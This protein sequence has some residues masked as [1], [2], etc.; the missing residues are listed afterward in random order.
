MEETGNSSEEHHEC[1]ERG[2]VAEEDVWDRVR[3]KKMIHDG[4]PKRNDYRKKKKFSEL[5]PKSDSFP[6]FLQEHHSAHKHGQQAYP[7]FLTASGFNI[8]DSLW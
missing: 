6:F 3:L 8:V 2:C 4:N 7:R 1:G 5:T